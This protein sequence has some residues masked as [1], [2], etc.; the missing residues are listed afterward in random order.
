MVIIITVG[1]LSIQTGS[2]GIHRYSVISSSSVMASEPSQTTLY[3]VY[4]P[5][6]E[7]NSATLTF[8]ELSLELAQMTDLFSGGMQLDIQ[9]PEEAE[10]LVTMSPSD[11]S[12]VVFDSA[13]ARARGFS[14]ESIRLAEQLTTLSNRLIEE[15]VQAQ[16]SGRVANIDEHTIELHE[17]PAVN[18]YFEQAR[19]ASQ[20][21]ALTTS[22]PQVEVSSW[23]REYHCGTYW[24]P[25]PS[26]AKNYVVFYNIRNPANTLRSWGYH[27]TQPGSY[28]GGGWTRPQTHRWWDCGWNTYR[29]HAYIWHNNQIH[30]QNYHGW[31]HRGEPNP[32]VWRSG[33]WPYSYWPSYV[34]WWHEWG[35]GR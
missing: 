8:E 32:E 12:P 10:T 17:F 3:R 2:N 25:L 13:T 18:D 6:V 30:E 24:R 11:V 22:I 31:S 23:W 33:P 26:R 27:P 34:Y 4:L 7:S 29:D 21:D 19:I 1:G 15:S 5:F 20:N 16:A 28:A 9:T 14:M 35:P